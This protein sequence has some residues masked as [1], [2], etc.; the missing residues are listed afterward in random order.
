MSTHTHRWEALKCA[1]GGLIN[2]EYVADGHKP[3]L[4][5]QVLEGAEFQ[6]YNIIQASPSVYYAVGFDGCEQCHWD[7]PTISDFV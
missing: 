5:K 1:Q 4:A 7:G 2:W 3:E 6:H